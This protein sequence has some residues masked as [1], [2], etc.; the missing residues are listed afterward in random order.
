MALEAVA[1]RNDEVSNRTL[2]DYQAVRDRYLSRLKLGK[3]SPEYKRAKQHI[4]AF[5]NE[6]Q[7]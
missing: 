5:I 2:I 7:S 4:E 6:L 1:I 3:Q